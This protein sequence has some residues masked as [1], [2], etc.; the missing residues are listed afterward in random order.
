MSN[1]GQP[2]FRKVTIH[3]PVEIWGD[4]LDGDIGKLREI[5]EAINE[6]LTEYVTSTIGVDVAATGQA[7]VTDGWDESAIPER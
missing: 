5:T 7:T 4:D 3:V 6:I 1:A 2:N